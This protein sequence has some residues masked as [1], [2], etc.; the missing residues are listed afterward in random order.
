MSVNSITQSNDERDLQTRESTRAPE[1]YVRPAVNIIEREEELILAADIPGASKE[2]IDINVDKGILTI[3][4]PLS[5]S[6]PGRSVYAEFELAPYFRQFQ[7]PENIQQEK[8]IASF[9]NGVLLL[10]LQKAEAARPR[11]IKISG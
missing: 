4:A 10:R 5:R 1:R 7:I 2:T 8:T 6:M 9:S 3:T 11:Q